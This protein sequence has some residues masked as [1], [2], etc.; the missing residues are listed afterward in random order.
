MS[1]KKLFKKLLA[2]MVWGNLLAMAVVVAALFVGMLWW[3][4]VYTHHGEGI[5]V[6]DMYGMAYTRAIEVADSKGLIVVAN[7]STYNKA[8]PAG[9]V[10]IQKPVAGMKVKEGRIIYVTINSLTMPRVALPDLIDNS[11][12]REA[13]AKLQALEF[14]VNPP[15][16]IDGEKDWVYGI[17]CEG[18]NLSAGDMVAKESTLTLVIGNGYL[19]DELELDD[20]MADSLLTD[21]ATPEEGLETVDEDDIDTFLEVF[22][23]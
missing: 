19:G 8:L 1:I 12:Y 5:E 10:V 23:Q 13:Q 20:L 7:D 18:R 15:V 6:P 2:P 4:G 22:E 9:C 21:P 17:R 3:L 16:L 11:S 14:K